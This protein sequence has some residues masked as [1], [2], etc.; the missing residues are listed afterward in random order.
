ML[1][2]LGVDGMADT[3]ASLVRAMNARLFSSTERRYCDGVCSNTAA[4]ADHTSLHASMFPLA[5]QLVPPE[6]M[7]SVVEWGVCAPA[8]PSTS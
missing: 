5:F 4:H 8:A 2:Q 6:Q 7:A 1:G 3:S